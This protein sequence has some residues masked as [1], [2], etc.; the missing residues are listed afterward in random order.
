M[1]C[2]AVCHRL[3]QQQ[4]QLW[5]RYV[6][7]LRTNIRLVIKHFVF[8]TADPDRITMFDH[9][10]FH[11]D[12]IHKG[13]VGAV[14]VPDG[15]IQLFR[16]V[17]I[18]INFKYRMFTTDIAIIQLQA[19]SMVATNSEIPFYHIDFRNHGTVN[20]M[21]QFDQETLPEYLLKNSV[22]NYRNNNR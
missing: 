12:I 8:I 19:V 16:Q 2:S 7:G 6:R 18:S 11:R 9:F 4:A 3:A 20:N 17:M 10:F 14:Q 15:D 13:P 22:F 21:L 1:C 5:L